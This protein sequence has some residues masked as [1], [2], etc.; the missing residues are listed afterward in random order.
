MIT[1]VLFLHNC[2]YVKLITEESAIIAIIGKS[3]QP[4][5]RLYLKIELHETHSIYSTVGE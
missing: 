5:P 4:I 2:I 3:V 1:L